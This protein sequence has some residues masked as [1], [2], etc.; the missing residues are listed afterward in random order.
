MEISSQAF[1]QASTGTAAAAGTGSGAISS[2]FETFLNMLTVQMQNQDPL[3]P[4]DSSD[5]AVQLATFSGV[6][7]QAK[8]NSL[9]EGLADIMGASGMA[10]MA[11]WVGKEARAP[12]EGYFNGNPITI[13]PNPVSVADSAQVIVSNAE[14]IEVERFDVAINADPFV[15]T[16]MDADGNPRDTGLYSFEIESYGNGEL[17]ARDPVDVYSTIT[18]VRSQ[19]G[20][21]V[22][23]LSGGVAISA[24]QVSAL[25]DPSLASQ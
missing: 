10:Q 24:A 7:Q 12:A 25:R 19:G 11:A 22:L 9:L 13:A 6:E 17:M 20:E 18:E 4:V 1:S 14:G 3:N 8:T 5:Y 21:S 15:W 16:G 23:I 2:D